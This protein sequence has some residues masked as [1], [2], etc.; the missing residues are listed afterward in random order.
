MAHLPVVPAPCHGELSRAPRIRHFAKLGRLNKI[1]LHH[2]T[3]F[4]RASCDANKITVPSKC[5]YGPRSLIPVT[6][7]SYSTS[8]LWRLSDKGRNHADFF[9][10]E[11]VAGDRNQF[12]Q[13]SGEWS[14][15]EGFCVESCA[16]H[17]RYLRGSLA[18]AV[19]SLCERWRQPV[20]GDASSLLY[21]T[22][23]AS[24]ANERVQHAFAS[25]MKTRDD[26]KLLPKIE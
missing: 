8:D 5:V 20:S 1:S 21:S 11:V 17:P 14:E 2:E 9:R 16:R 22:G 12:G 10:R 24:A 23:G 7:R 6:G 25:R 15:G 26:H 19:D 3:R 13:P 18:L 4:G